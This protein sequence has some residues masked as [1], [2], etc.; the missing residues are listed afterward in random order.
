MS[1]NQ[2]EG[3]YGGR[4]AGKH[5]RTRWVLGMPGASKTRRQIYLAEARKRGRALFDALV[6]ADQ[7]T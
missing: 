5:S 2:R 7:A 1:R 6:A 3:H 4:Y